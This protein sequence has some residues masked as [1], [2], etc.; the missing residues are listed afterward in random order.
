MNL[1]TRYLGLKLDSPI[2]ASASPL[3]RKV[4]NIQRMEEHGA[5]AVVLFSMFEEQ[6][7]KEQEAAH[8]YL[9]VGADSFTESSG[10]FPSADLYDVTT[11]HYLKIFKL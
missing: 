4:E 6:I 3:C 5:S 10:F 1:T 2:V 9:D 11:N 7:R 8:H